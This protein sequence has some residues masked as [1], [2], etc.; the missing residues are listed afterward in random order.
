VILDVWSRRVVGYALGRQ[1]DMRLTL[2]ALRAAVNARHPPRGLIHRTD[3]GAQY[4]AAS[5][6]SELAA[7]GLVGS[8][9]RRRNQSLDNERAESFIKTRKC[10]EVY[11]SD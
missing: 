11:L 9:S 8:I 4:A 10:E 3:R 7:H 6:R 5:Y 1:I 2:A